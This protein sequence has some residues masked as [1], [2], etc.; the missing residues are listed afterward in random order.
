MRDLKGFPR[1]D[2]RCPT[3]QLLR[4]ADHEYFQQLS[5]DRHLKSV[6][7]HY[8]MKSAKFADGGDSLHILRVHMNILNKQSLIVDKT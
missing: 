4:F 1:A 2:N 3:Y 8:G 7:L 6:H 5:E